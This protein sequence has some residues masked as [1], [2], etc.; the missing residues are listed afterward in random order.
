MVRKPATEL[1]LLRGAAKR[2]MGRSSGSP[3]IG[4]PRVSAKP[5]PRA[6]GPVEGMPTLARLLQGFSRRGRELARRYGIVSQAL[7]GDADG[8]L[9]RLKRL[10]GALCSS[11][12]EASGV[13][14]AADLLS[15]YRLA[16]ISE[17]ADFF[18]HLAE[19]YDPEPS[20]IL[21]A[22]E[23]Y[24]AEGAHCL[25]GLAE[26]VEAPR[27]ELFRRLNLAPDGTS[28]LVRM[29]QD[30]LRAAATDKSRLSRV[31]ADLSHL[32][33][34]WFNRGFLA[35]RRLDWSTPAAVLER[36]ILYEA[37]HDIGDWDELR[38]RLDPPDRR[39]YAFFHPALADEP[40]IFVEVALTQEVSTSVQDIL[41][42]DRDIVDPRNAT[43][44][45]FYS[46]SNCQSGLRGISFGHFLI[47]QVANDLKRDHPE[48]TTFATLSPMPGFRDHI[49]GAAP[50]LE[51]R[52]AAAAEQ[53]ISDETGDEL[54]R[55]MEAA[56]TAYMV[57]AKTSRGEPA[58]PVAR[59][60]LGN[61]ARL[62]RLNWR[63]DITVN[64]IRKSGGLMVNYLYD[65]DRL[66]ENH[67]EYAHRNTLALGA[68]FRRLVDRFAP[69]SREPRA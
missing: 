51:G 2:D 54:R 22:W 27:Q 33:Q 39:C 60:H 64:G 12:G 66:E 35:M 10:A 61:G 47:K 26:A 57:D 43:T 46:I 56:A 15:A 8:T 7:S 53:I 28:S 9:E 44:A 16:S 13:A 40:L 45:I 24:R 17:R 42:A 29:R 67:E 11:R 55:D 1:S 63:A 21:R 68:P 58:D 31:D 38:R 3:T 14:L 49:A 62:E 41:S 5:Q 4:D 6:R 25:P 50:S 69:V 59:F 19:H 52:I 18:V 30:L 20:V 34:S 48:L 32:L 37:V 65:L 36:L 23:R